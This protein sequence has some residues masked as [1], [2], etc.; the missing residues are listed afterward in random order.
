M[1]RVFAI[2]LVSAT[3]SYAQG[4]PDARRAVVVVDPGDPIEVGHLPAH[5]RSELLDRISVAVRAAVDM[6]DGV[7]GTG[8]TSPSE[9]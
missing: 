8:A 9:S 7:P 5:E 3:L 6:E 2:V 1:L 4:Y